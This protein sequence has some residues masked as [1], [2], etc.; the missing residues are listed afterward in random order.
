MGICVKTIAKAISD[1]KDVY[2]V[3]KEPILVGERIS[4]YKMTE[5]VTKLSDYK[6]GVM[7]KFFDSGVIL[8]HKNLLQFE[9]DRL[10]GTSDQLHDMQQNVNKI[11]GKNRKLKDLLSDMITEST[12]FHKNSDDYKHSY[13]QCFIAARAVFGCNNKFAFTLASGQGKSIVGLLI[14]AYYKRKGKKVSIVSPSKQLKIQ[15]QSELYKLKKDHEGIE[16]VTPKLM[17]KVS[18]DMDICIVDEADF[19]LEE[20]HFIF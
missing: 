17:S 13:Y 14:A 5:L 2:E 8:A 20:K 12:E 15:L 4:A 16:V 6:Y 19:L 7:R 18:Q 1:E 10:I 11:I 9:S 3:L